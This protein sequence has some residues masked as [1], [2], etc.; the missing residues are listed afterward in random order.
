MRELLLAL[1]DCSLK[2]NGLEKMAEEALL[3]EKYDLDIH[4][5]FMCRKAMMLS[6]LPDQLRPLM[7]GL[8]RRTLKYV[9][10]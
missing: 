4:Y 2:I 10:D 3:V 9:I 1:K 8:D 6:R 7:D 5:N